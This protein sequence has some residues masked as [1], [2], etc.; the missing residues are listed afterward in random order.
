MRAKKT[1]IYVRKFPSRQFSL[2]ITTFTAWFFCL[3]I[4]SVSISE[5]GNQLTIQVK[6]QNRPAVCP[7][8]NSTSNRV[9]SNYQRSLDDVSWGNYQ[10]CLKLSTQ[11]LFCTNSNCERRIFTIRLPEIAAPNRKT[12]TTIEYSTN[13]SRFSSRRITRLTFNS[14]LGNHN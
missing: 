1:V 2:V 3:K 4:T 10:V 12:N 13:Q 7:I 8:C 14:A 5:T 9:H 6:T 11:K